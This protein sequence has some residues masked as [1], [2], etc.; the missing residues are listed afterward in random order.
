MYFPECFSFPVIQQHPI[1]LKNK[2]WRRGLR[3]LLVSTSFLEVNKDF[4]DDHNFGELKYI[5]RV[6]MTC[7]GLEIQSLG[8][9]T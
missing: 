7:L 4:R 5:R 8:L 2:S 3:C 6:L 9:L 1:K